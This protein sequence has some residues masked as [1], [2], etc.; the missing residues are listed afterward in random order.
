MAKLS[1]CSH[2]GMARLSCV[3]LACVE[4]TR[5][6]LGRVC[7]GAAHHA[8]F[9]PRSAV[10]CGRHGPL[11]HACPQSAQGVGGQD[12]WRKDAD[13]RHQVRSL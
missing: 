8:L 10:V 3:V 6:S 5:L 11:C 7:V 4:A 13:C 1:Y 2:G 9:N 12:T